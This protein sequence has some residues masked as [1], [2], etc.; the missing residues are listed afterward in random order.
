MAESPRWTRIVLA[1][2]LTGAVLFALTDHDKDDRDAAAL[3]A[4]VTPQRIDIPSLSLKAPLMK[5]GLTKA[6][7][8]ELPPFGKPETAG[9]YT[10]SAVP[11][12]SGASVII[13]HVDTKTAPAVF[14][15]LRDL[16]KGA[17][18][19]V[20]RSDGKVAKYQVESIQEVPKTEF[21]TDRVYT[22]DGLRLV[23][24]GGAFDWARHQYRDN[25]I[26]Y[27]SLVN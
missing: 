5:L 9:W 10:G 4:R 27:A 23:T 19:R 8:V 12:D 7:A 2:A 24:C 26:V 13:G 18:V 11:G 6:G 15:H 17:I 22:T 16:R 1:G 3:P 21:P 25:I 20:S 14:Y